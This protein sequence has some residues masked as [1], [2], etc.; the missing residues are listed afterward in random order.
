MMVSPWEIAG[1]AVSMTRID[2]H[3]P[4]RERTRNVKG[5][6]QIFRECATPPGG[7]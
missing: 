2:F 7:V 5:V 1:G 6:W 4:R 3:A